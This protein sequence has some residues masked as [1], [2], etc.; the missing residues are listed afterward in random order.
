AVVLA[1]DRER[2]RHH[3]TERLHV[4]PVLAHRVGLLGELGDPGPLQQDRVG[5]ALDSLL[6]HARGGGDLRDR[7]TG[8]DAGLNFAWAHLA[9]QTDLDLTEP[10]ELAPSSA[11]Q[12]FDHGDRVLRAWVVYA[13]AALP[14]FVVPDPP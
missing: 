1:A 10:T 5:E 8:A 4:R 3:V 13:L 11:K 14:G 2:V 12:P 9:L 7:L 6:R